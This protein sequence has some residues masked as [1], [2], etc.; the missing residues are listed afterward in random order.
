MGAAFTHPTSKLYKTSLRSDAFVCYVLAVKKDEIRNK[1]SVL[2][3]LGCY[4]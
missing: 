4:L 2:N 1:F 3:L